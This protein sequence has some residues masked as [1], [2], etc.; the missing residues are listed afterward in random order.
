MD[1]QPDQ[2]ASRRGPHTEQGLA[3]SSLNAKT[4]G[5]T[6]RKLVLPGES[7]ADLDLLLAHYHAKYPSADPV[8]ESMVTRAAH[9]DWYLQRTQR[10]FDATMAEL[11]ETDQLAWTEDQHKQYQRAH[12]YLTADQ[13]QLDRA[14]QQILQDYRE[15]RAAQRLELAM[16]PKQ[17]KPAEPEPAPLSKHPPLPCY[18]YIEIFYVKGETSFHF[19]IT[20]KQVLETLKKSPDTPHILRTIEFKSGEI[21]PEYAWLPASNPKAKVTYK[22]DH[23]EFRAQAALEPEGRICPT[24]QDNVPAA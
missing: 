8:L 6:A 1:E 12:R 13:R 10:G 19:H 24:P 14:R 11:Y 2:P 20:N 16:S 17:T 3:I 18:Q 5:M 4:H 23:D 7:Q 9:A 22:F 15:T 21:P